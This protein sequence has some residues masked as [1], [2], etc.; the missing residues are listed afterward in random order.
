MA[1]LLLFVSLTIKP[2]RYTNIVFKGQIQTRQKHDF[3]HIT[4]IMLWFYAVTF[5]TYCLNICV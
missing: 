4:D 1:K 5:D 2:I 3:L